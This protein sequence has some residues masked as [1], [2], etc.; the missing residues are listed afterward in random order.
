MQLSS[1]VAAEATYSSTCPS[2]GMYISRLC[3]GTSS[4]CIS[5]PRTSSMYYIQ[6]RYAHIELCDIAMMPFN[7]GPKSRE[8]RHVIYS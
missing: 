1:A 3:Y 4:E 2:V 5:A 6:S 7:R 8:D